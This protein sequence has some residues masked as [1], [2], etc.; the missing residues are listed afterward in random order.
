MKDKKCVCVCAHASVPLYMRVYIFERER[1]M[2]SVS[3]KSE[4]DSEEGSV[5]VEHR[6]AAPFCDAL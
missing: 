3:R 6:A 5:R 1:K 2:E 4:G